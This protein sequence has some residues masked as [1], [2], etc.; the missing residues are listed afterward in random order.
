MA[1]CFDPVDQ[2]LDEW[3]QADMHFK[4]DPSNSCG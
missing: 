1:P 2:L 4:C 3:L